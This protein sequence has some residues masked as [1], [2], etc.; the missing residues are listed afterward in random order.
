MSFLKNIVKELDNEY[1]GLA[2]D[3]V[4]GDTNGFIDTGSYAFNALLSGSIYGGLPSNKVTALAGESSTGKTFYAL[5]IAGNFLRTND[6]A[7][8]IY[9]VSTPSVLLL[10]LFLLFKS[11]AL[12]HLKFLMLMR[13]HQR[14]IDSH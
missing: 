3:G 8:V 12:K 13:K 4:V 1:A 9:V 5:G 2:D 14:K 6:Q 10:F 11:F 7:G